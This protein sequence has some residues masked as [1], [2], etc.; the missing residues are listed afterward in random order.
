ML[1]K[2]I[3]EGQNEGPHLLITA[4]IHGDE[5][6]PMEACRRVYNEV[7]K[8]T[9][10]LSGK[11]TIVPVVN[12]P[13]FE[14]NSRTGSDQLDLARVCPGNKKGSETEKIASAVSELIRTA[15]YYIDMHNGGRLHN[16]YPFSGYMLHPKESVLDAQRNLAKSFM[17]PIVWGTDPAMEGRTLS[18]A[19]D[20]NIPSIYIEI[21][22][23]GIYD[24][25]MTGLAYKGCINVLK[26]LNMLPEKAKKESVMIHLEDF[27]KQ[28]GHLQKLLP[29]PCDGFYLP[30]VSLGQ[31]VAK[32]DII[33]YVQDILGENSTSIRADHDGLIFI[34]RNPP[35]VKQGDALGAILPAIEHD[36]IQSIYE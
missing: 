12:E 22:G 27:R 5:Y 10:K 16:I 25:L 20:A 3:L 7:K 2:L 28:S 4:G 19:R 8:I 13:A 23:A 1:K 31:R 9:N 24:E 35:S 15:D 6:E 18:V 33:G 36:K 17:L 21:G 26:H 14:L 34:L 32:G 11:L 30:K 29:S